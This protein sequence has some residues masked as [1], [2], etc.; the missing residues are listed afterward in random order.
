VYAK[1]GVKHAPAANNQTVSTAPDQPVAITLTAT[2][3]DGDALAFAILGPPAHGI[4]SAFDATT[5]TVTYTPTPGWQGT[6]SFTFKAVDSTGL[7]S[8]RGRVTVELK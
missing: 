6:D 3:E 2:D 4:L 1:T 8:N 7:N 5:G